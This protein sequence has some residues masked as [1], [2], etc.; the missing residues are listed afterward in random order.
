[1][2][3]SDAVQI[4]HASPDSL[5]VYFPS[6]YA[7]GIVYLVLGVTVAALAFKLYHQKVTL[8]FF[9]VMGLFYIFGGL[10][11]CTYH[12]SV[13]FSA[14]TQ[15]CSYREKPFTTQPQRHSHSVLLSKR[16]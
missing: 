8:I 5:Q 16:S 6:R 7:G 3:F 2:N 14:K 9:G 10:D 11:L 12:G 1:M 15:T 4:I 13:T